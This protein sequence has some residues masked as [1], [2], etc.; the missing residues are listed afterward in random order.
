MQTAAVVDCIDEFREVRRGVFEAFER[1][2][3]N[4]LDLQ[5]L[6]EALHL[7]VIV[8][9]ATPAH[10]ADEPMSS[11]QLAI[12]FS[13]VLGAAI[14][15]MHATGRGAG[16][17]RSPPAVPPAPDACRWSGLWHSRPR[18][19]TKRPGSPRHT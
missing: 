14:G 5:R 17:M 16:A 7:G 3:V 13:S 19:A 6:H 4:G 10:G 12:R 15:V 18:G 9:V 1:H 11:E 2:R 8:R